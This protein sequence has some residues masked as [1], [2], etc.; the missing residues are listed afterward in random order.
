MKQQLLLF[1][2]ALIIITIS[3]LLFYLFGDLFIYNQLYEETNDKDKQMVN[4]SKKKYGES[5][6]PD[7]SKD[8][9]SLTLCYQ[10]QG[11]CENMKCFDSKYIY[12]T[13]IKNTS[14][15]KIDLIFTNTNQDLF[16]YYDKKQNTQKASSKITLTIDPGKKMLILFER[17]LTAT[18]ELNYHMKSGEVKTLLDLSI[19]GN[20][21]IIN[22]KRNLIWPH[23]EILNENYTICKNSF[24]NINGTVSNDCLERAGKDLHFELISNTIRGNTINEFKPSGLEIIIGDD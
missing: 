11:Y 2:Y 20:K 15:N 4:L 13:S 7:S 22:I 24:N 8:Q 23:F 6:A 5:D 12:K 9:D 16:I 21:G 3:C 1:S 19:Q 10:C 18:G 14:Q 17:E